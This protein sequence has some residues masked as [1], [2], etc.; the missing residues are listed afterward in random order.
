SIGNCSYS[1][2]IIPNGME[3]CC[4][5]TLNLV[6]NYLTTGGILLLLREPPEFVNGIRDER[7]RVLAGKFRDQWQCVASFEEL[8][9]KLDELVPPLITAHKGG[10]LPS[11]VGHHMRILDE[12]EVLHFVVNHSSSS[13]LFEL[14]ISGDDVYEL[15]TITGATLRPDFRRN[16]TE[17][18]IPLKLPT[19]GHTVLLVSK[20]SYPAKKRAKLRGDRAIAISSFE[21]IERT[22]PNVLGLDFCDLTLSDS[23]RR[24][25]YVTH[26]N[27]L[28]WQAHGFD[29]DIW[30]RAVQF[31]RNYF[32]F[33]F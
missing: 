28:C 5:I 8:Q 33:Q 20:T 26:A 9:Q 27:R 2:L 12:D 23:M 22:S 7:A 31:R 13:V 15:E 32:D 18:V 1:V 11:T 4:D 30:D 25:L 16:G 24:G 10:H 6:E 17:I 19:A 3:N 21:R 29:R 14:S